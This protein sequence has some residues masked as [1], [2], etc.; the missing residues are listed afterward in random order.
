MIPVEAFISKT[1]Y[2]YNPFCLKKTKIRLDVVVTEKGRGHMRNKSLTAPLKPDTVIFKFSD[3][4][5]KFFR[6][7]LNYTVKVSK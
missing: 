6:P 4:N 7:G 3:D 2:L 1:R 5:P